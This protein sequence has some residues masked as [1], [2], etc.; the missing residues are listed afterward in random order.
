MSDRSKSEPAETCFHCGLPVGA[1]GVPPLLHGG[2]QRHFCCHGCKAVCEAIIASGNEDYYDY[3]EGPTATVQPD[4][5]ER[6]LGRLPLYDRA[7]IQKDFVR[8]APDGEEAWLILENIHCAAC[9]WLNERFLR[10]LDGVLEC[11][12]DYT[13]Q[14]ARVRWDPAR[15][16]LSEILFAISQIGY[17]AH[18]FDP[19]RREALEEEQRQRSVQ[20]LIFAAIL[21]MT[22]MNF[23]L[24]SYVFGAPDAQGVYPLWIR[25]ARWTNLLASGLLLAYPGQLFFRNAW[26]DLRRRRLGMDV[27]VALGLSLAW[28]GSLKATV[29]GSGEVYFESIAMFV[30]LLLVAR[31][32]ELRARMQ[33]AALLDRTARVIPETVRRVAGDGQEDAFV[34]DLQVGDR[35][36]LNPGEMVPTD[37]K[38]VGPASSFDES[39]LT[40]ESLPVVR[41]PGESVAGG[42]V[43]IDQAV[44]MEVERTSADSTLTA[45]QRMARSSVND[46]PQYVQLADRVAGRFIGAILLVAAITG[47]GWWFLDPGAAL[48]NTISV[49]IVTCP[50]AL[51]LASPVALTLC[52]GGLAK[53]GILPVHL[54]AIETV[55][56]AD[57]LVLD[58]TGTLTLGRPML[59]RTLVVEGGDPEPWLEIAAALEAGSEHPFARAFQGQ[60]IPPD[61]VV[62]RRCNYPGAGVEGEIEGVDWRL[63][64]AAFV[65]LAADWLTEPAN[66]AQVEAWQAQGGSVLYLGTESRLAAVFFLE[67]P[68]RPGAEDFVA[69]ARRLG[70]SRILV[71]S[72]DHPESTRALASRIGADEARGGLSPADKCAV[73][74]QLQEAGSTVLM[75]GDGLNDAPVLAAADVSMAIAEATDLARSHS[76][77]LVLARELGGLGAALALM[78]QTRSVIVQNLLWAVVYNLLAVPAAAM[79]MISPA[80]AALGMSASSLAVVLNSLRLRHSREEKK[81]ASAEKP[82]LHMLKTRL[83]AH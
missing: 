19:A 15:I 67:D 73:V 53:R 3:R 50:C 30:M 8:H 40:G 37:A 34:A 38:L 7:E 42:A 57:V 46:K 36:L 12:M 74:R 22:I 16:K 14:Q 66:R 1:A 24:A 60:A 63:G 56:K 78:K 59:Q 52:S 39:L 32:V 25:I 49:L 13:S 68:P 79:G 76:D 41:K 11:E 23:S 6:L 35:I 83:R 72:G 82:F 18:P 28:L 47:L 4:E 62:G 43:N 27:P 5:L 75:L 44:T 58:K 77:F 54:A 33:A 81:S 64:N 2:Q 69:E 17:V 65:S 80:I 20:R 48:S 10:R 71:L 70:F 51:A 29:T 31:H 21:G 61:R 26:R 45:I 55:A 9:L